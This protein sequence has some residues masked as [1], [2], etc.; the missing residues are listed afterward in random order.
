M[1]MDTMEVHPATLLGLLCAGLEQP[2]IP[3]QPWAL[4]IAVEVLDREAP[5]SSVLSRSLSCVRRRGDPSRDRRLDVASLLRGLVRGGHLRPEGSGWHAGYAVSS[6]WLDRQVKLFGVLP[7]TD[8]AALARASQRFRAVLAALRR[9]SSHRL[10]GSQS[11][12]NLRLAG[13]AADDR[14]HFAVT[15]RSRSRAPRDEPRRYLAHDH[16]AGSP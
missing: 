1:I 15:A 3:A 12:R 5:A 8:R 9:R 7:A 4:E 14:D 2:R 11:C 10:E 13:L 16:R 6:N